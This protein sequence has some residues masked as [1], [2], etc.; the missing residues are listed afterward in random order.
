MKWRVLPFKTYNAAENMA[1]DEHLL[2]TVS[3]GDAPTIRFYGWKPEAVSIGYFQSVYEEVDI[4]K[5]KSDGIEIVRRITG[6]GAVF[7]SEEITYSLIAPE[8]MF[9]RDIIKSYKTICLPIITALKKIG[10]DAKF[11]PINDIV[12]G[13]KKISGNAQTRRKKVLLQHGTILYDVDVER[14]FSYLKVPDEK[15][16]DKIIKNV[17]E[18]VA[19]VKKHINITKEELYEG[20]LKEF[21][22]GKEWEFSEV[23]EGFKEF[24]PKYSSWEWIGKK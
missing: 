3:R 17:K 1:I 5:C 9:E 20:L 2:N 16:K 12:V 6:G 10:L 23:D 22:N 15:I 7:H 18:R 11:V 14:M 4:E 13:N 24:L 19:G 8:K 21:V